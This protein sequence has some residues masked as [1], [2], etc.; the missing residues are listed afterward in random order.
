MG[1]VLNSFK[2]QVSGTLECKFAVI[3]LYQITELIVGDFQF[4][5]ITG[6]K[7]KGNIVIC[8][9]MIAPYL[10]SL[11]DDGGFRGQPGRVVVF[12]VL[13]GVFDQCGN[14]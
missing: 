8:A 12:A 6:F 14:E 3:S 5:P 10:R 13:L 4:Q 9:G 1:Y 7:L 11:C 2:I